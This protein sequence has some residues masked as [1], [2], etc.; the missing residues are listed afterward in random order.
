MV[1]EYFHY[2]WYFPLELIPQLDSTHLAT[3]QT[4]LVSTANVYAH[5]YCLI[6]KNLTIIELTMW[7]SVCVAI[8]S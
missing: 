3:T 6:L 2:S 4:S 5:I 1:K 8:D 7:L